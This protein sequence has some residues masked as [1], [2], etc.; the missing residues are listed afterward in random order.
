M[1]KLHASWSESTF[2]W[3]I[4]K[5]SDEFRKLSPEF[6]LQGFP[7][8]LELRKIRTIQD[9]TLKIYLSRTNDVNNVELTCMVIAEYKVLSFDENVKSH[10]KVLAATQYGAENS[11]MIGITLISLNEINNPA[12]NFIRNDSIVLEIH[13][14]TDPPQTVFPNDS[15]RLQI[16]SN[17]RSTI[18]VNLMVKGFDKMVGIPSTF[19]SVKFVGNFVSIKTMIHWTFPCGPYEKIH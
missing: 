17:H 7:F 14:K 16:I 6:Q 3:V 12:R 4:T 18:K 1:A 2:C 9:S 11:S 19:H 13:V 5:F 10:R 15:A 8:Q